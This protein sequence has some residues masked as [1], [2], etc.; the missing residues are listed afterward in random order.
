MTYLSYQRRSWQF[1]VSDWAPPLPWTAPPPPTGVSTLPRPTPDRP[2]PST[3]WGRTELLQPRREDPGWGLQGPSPG[4][5]SS[6]LK[7]NLPTISPTGNFPRSVQNFAENWL[8]ELEFA[9]HC[10]PPQSQGEDVG[11]E[12]EVPRE[13]LPDS[14]TQSRHEQSTNYRNT[15]EDALTVLL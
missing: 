6:I 3:W 10:L 5:L 14:G 9:G 4:S 11:R 2:P 1:N 15:R 13:L 8:F 7:T 12:E